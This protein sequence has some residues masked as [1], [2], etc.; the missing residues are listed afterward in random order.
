MIFVYRAITVYGAPFQRTSTDFALRV[1]RSYNPGPTRR[2]VWPVPVSLATTR[3]I[4]FDFSSSGYLDVSVPL[5]CSACAVTGLAS[6]RVSPFGHL[7]INACVPLPQAYRS[8]P[9][10]SSPLCAQASPTYL[11]SLDSFP[12]VRQTIRFQNSF[13]CNVTRSAPLQAQTA[14]RRR[15]TEVLRP[16]STNPAE[17][18]I[19]TVVP[20]ITSHFRCQI[21]Q[22]PPRPSLRRAAVSNRIRDR[23]CAERAISLGLSVCRTSG[24]PPNCRP[25]HH[26]RKEVIQPQVPLRL[27]CYDF[28]PVTAL[29]LGGLAPCGFRHRLRAL[30]ASMA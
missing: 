23:G 18:R 7:G 20:T 22:T 25:T 14:T 30:T 5:V 27:P 1:R 2:P 3:G 13:S 10:P 12:L 26:S 8:L 17:G 28:A 19:S 15:L 29:A 21:A 11:R 4:S 24:L 9:R 6:G 16:S